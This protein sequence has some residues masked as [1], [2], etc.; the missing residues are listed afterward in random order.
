MPARDAEHYSR[1]DADGQCQCDMETFVLLMYGRLSP[2]IAVANGR[3]VVEGTR[4]PM[5]TLGTWFKF[6]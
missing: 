1:A 3:L 6:S 5:T 2:S 4:D